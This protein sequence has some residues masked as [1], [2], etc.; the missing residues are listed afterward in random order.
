M[1]IK[2][3]SN[4]F[5]RIFLMKIYLSRVSQ[6]II[7]IVISGISSWLVDAGRGLKKKIK[8]KDI[9]FLKNISLILEIYEQL[10]TECV[11]Q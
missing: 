10:F 3:S 5:N 8:K 4:W 9:F 2:L 11:K 6:L 7:S 1:S